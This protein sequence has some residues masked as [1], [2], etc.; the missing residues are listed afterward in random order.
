ME[1]AHC[2]Q[3]QSIPPVISYEKVNELLEIVH[4]ST[5]C[6]GNPDSDF[7]KIVA[8]RKDK[9]IISP[10]GSTAAY[11]DEHPIAV[12]GKQYESTVRSG[13]CEILSIR[14]KCPGCVSYRDKLRVMHHRKVAKSKRSP[15]TYTSTSSRANVRF[16]TTPLRLKRYKNLKSRAN[17]AEK[18]VRRLKEKISQL[19]EATA[20]EVSTDLHQDLSQIMKDNDAE[21]TRVFSSGSFQRLFWAH[22]MK[23]IQASDKRQVRWHPMMIKWCLHLKMLSSAAYRAM[24]KS[25]LLPSERTLRD[26]THLVKGS[27]GIQPE[28]NSLLRKEAK[29]PLLEDWQKYV[30]VTFDEMKIKED[31]VYDKNTCDVIGYINLDEVNNQLSSL[32]H[33]LQGAD[34]KPEEF[35]ADHY[36]T[37]YGS[38]HIYFTRI[39]L[40]T[41][42]YSDSI[43][44]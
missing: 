32:G 3:L 34:F 33:A 12:N 38:W 18:T 19:T 14:S 21:V 13:K 26:Y 40:C 1:R 28:V 16:M 10:D 37:L 43:W 8:A 15:S 42:C 44:N 22:Q 39:S 27:T 25:I 30:C 11:L 23:A 6:C 31:I 9:R 20:V 17:L 5:V 24:R 7:V 36:A 41:V 4:K 29:V 2:K 35:V